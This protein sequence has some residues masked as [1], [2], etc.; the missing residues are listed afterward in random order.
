MEKIENPVLCVLLYIFCYDLWF[1][2]SHVLLHTKWFYAIHKIHHS[3]PYDLLT[4]KTTL[5]S[6]TIENMLQPLGIVVP[7][8]FIHF[9]VM[10][11]LLACIFIG[12]RGLMRHDFRFVWLVGNHHLL[13]HKYQ[14]VN[15]GDYYLDYLFGTA[16]HTSTF[17]EDL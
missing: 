16:Y 3:T 14:N 1:Y 15:F 2:I 7:I 13:H 9:R 8:C 6:H 17:K 12:L 4:Y 11:L 5:S 10:D